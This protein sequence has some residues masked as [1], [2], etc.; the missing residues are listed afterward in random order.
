MVEPIIPG[1]AILVARK[2]NNSAIFEKPL[3]YLKVWIYLLTQSQHKDFKELKRGQI[4]TSIP[5]IQKA[6]SWKVGFRTESA[7][8]NQILNILNWLQKPSAGNNQSPLIVVEKAATEMLITI[9]NYDSYQ[10]DQ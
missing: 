5:Q 4:F 3:L 1:G 10:I 7:S 6:V 9:C 8:R 2:L